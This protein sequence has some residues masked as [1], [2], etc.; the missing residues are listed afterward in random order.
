MTDEVSRYVPSNDVIIL[1]A[2]MQWTVDRGRGWVDWL[3]G[4]GNIEN[5]HENERGGRWK[6]ED[7]TRNPYD[8]RRV[9]PGDQKGE[10]D[11]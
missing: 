11:G 1:D 10:A 2:M 7:R 6:V 8:K 3:F 5:E 9:K 4:N